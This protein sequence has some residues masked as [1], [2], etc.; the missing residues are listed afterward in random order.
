MSGVR[1]LVQGSMKLLI[2][3]CTIWI[4]DSIMFSSDVFK[5]MGFSPRAIH[6]AIVFHTG[7]LFGYFFFKPCYVFQKSSLF[8]T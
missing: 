4:C 6:I 5:T 7:Q 3:Q 1:V 2:F 8:L